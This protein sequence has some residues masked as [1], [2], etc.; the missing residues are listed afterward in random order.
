MRIR[1]TFARTG[2]IAALLGTGLVAGCAYND[3]L[4]R[5]Q[6]VIV[7][8][9]ALEQASVAAW[10]QILRTQKQSN[11]RA[12]ND[13]V[14]QVGNRIVQAAGLQNRQWTYAVFEDQV[15][16]AFVLPS[17]H[18]GVTTGLLRMTRNDDQLATVI[19]HEV[20]HVVG[21][22]A[23]ERTS[24]SSLTQLALGAV[25]RGAGDYGQAVG[26]FGGLGAQLGFLLPFSRR[27]ELEADRLGIDYMTRA[28]Y[29]A[30]ESITLWQA[31]AAAQNRAGTP[32]FASTHPS[33]QTRI[34][35]LEAYIAQRGY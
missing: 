17:G 24:T 2:L 23:A 18:M 4:G 11:D 25:Q 28:G 33:D 8:D 6:V 34:A 10:E 20:A 30:R 15:P 7:D 32:E 21:R 29:R 16:N 35:A 22:H 5:N 26:A 13:R 12:M 9:R 14:R 19:G 3:T 27:H 1:T 31:M